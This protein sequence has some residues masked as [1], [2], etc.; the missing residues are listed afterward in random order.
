MRKIFFKI[1]PLRSS[2]RLLIA[3]G[4]LRYT[5]PFGTYDALPLIGRL[6][7]WVA[8]IVVAG[9]PIH[10]CV[11]FLTRKFNQT[12]RS[13]IASLFAGVVI[14]SI[15]ATAAVMA[16]FAYFVGRSFDMVTYPVMWGNVVVIGLVIA[17][18]QFWP[19]IA[20][21]STIPA[22]EQPPSP[23]PPP[24]ETSHKPDLKPIVPLLSKISQYAEPEDIISFSMRDHYVEITTRNG[25]E[26][27]LM[28]FQDINNLLGDLQGCRLH[29]SH[30]A[31]AA[32]VTDLRRSGRAHEVILSDGRT[33]PFSASYL[34]CVK[35]MLEEKSA[36]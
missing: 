13:A 9:G 3:A 23:P 12:R 22:T 31:A 8:A 20:H 11:H 19:R 18:I 4:V 6:L 1:G 15:P 27:L 10:V 24:D 14:G 21:I 34:D 29:R 17:V 7:F 28:R 35:T 36:A 25:V 30:W 33:L 2:I 26:M 32:H 5:G 16:V